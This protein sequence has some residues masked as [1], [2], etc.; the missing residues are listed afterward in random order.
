[1][2]KMNKVLIQINMTNCTL[3]RI[4]EKTGKNGF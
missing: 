3:L 4:K 2:N 1:M